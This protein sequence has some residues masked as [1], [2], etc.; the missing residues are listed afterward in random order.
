M[1]IPDTMTCSKTTMIL[2]VWAVG[3]LGAAAG[4]N[5]KVDL[6]PGDRAP[7]FEAVDD[8]GQPWKSADY[9]GKKYVVL[10]FYPGDFTPGCNVQARSFRD[11]M[12][13]LADKGVMVI[14]VS[15]DAVHTHQMFKKAQE[16][17]FTLLADEDGSLAKK[18]GVPLGKGGE[19]KTK[20]AAGQPVTLTRKVTAARWTFVIGKDGNIASI[21][22]KVI[23]AQDSK[24]VVDLI[25]KLEKQ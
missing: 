7:A 22:T 5:P 3:C 8:Q 9:I 1:K 12:N 15:G 16:L 20:D 25:E 17:N 14:G 21:N 23:P 13:K 6:K 4:D 11:N 18:F 24:Q 2:V 10:Y 19:V